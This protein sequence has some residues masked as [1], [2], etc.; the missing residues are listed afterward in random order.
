LG[1]GDVIVVAS[2][3]VSRVEGRFVDLRT[4]LVSPRAQEI[5]AATGKDPRLVE[6]ILRDTEAISRTGPNALVVRHSRG[7]VTG[8]AGI[9]CSNAAPPG[10]APGEWAL[11]LP[12]AP[13]ASAERIRG[14]LA[15]RTGAA[16]GVIIS[17]S[18]GRPF[19]IGT[20]GTA[21]GVAGLPA[22]WDQ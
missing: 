6:L 11:L 8:D 7:C 10:E 19:R 22:I 15:G 2:K 17:D 9:A 14:A 16:I 20:V 5:A 1:D 18:F 12:E 21:I 13:D 4:V 3:A